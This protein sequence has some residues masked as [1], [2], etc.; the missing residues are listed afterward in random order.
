MEMDVSLYGD[1]LSN[2][3]AQV[4]QHRALLFLQR[5]RDIGIH[6]QHD[7]MAVQIGADFLDLRENLIAD[8]RARLDHAG[9]RAV[10]ARLGHYPF[11]ALLHALARDDDE[12]EVRYL[13]R[14]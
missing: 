13:Q 5:P 4:L 2:R 12:A 1:V 8:R 10:R 11:E 14:L 3:R 6:A 7:A 9:A